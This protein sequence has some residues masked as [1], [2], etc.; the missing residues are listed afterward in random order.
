MAG[1]GKDGSRISRWYRE[2]TASSSCLVGGG[3]SGPADPTARNK[4]PGK[5]GGLDPPAPLADLPTLQLLWM[6]AT[7]KRKASQ[8]AAV[9]GGW[10]VIINLIP[11]KC[12]HQSSIGLSTGTHSGITF[13][14]PNCH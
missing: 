12:H 1:V 7:A 11:N 5:G 9:R 8:S 14:R 10:I 4:R 2:A 13:P 3:K 6:P